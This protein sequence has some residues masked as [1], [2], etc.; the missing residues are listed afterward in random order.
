LAG[1]LGE[2]CRAVRYSVGH[3]DA[4]LT[5][6]EA[7]SIA[8]SLVEEW[9]SH[10]GPPFPSR[11]CAVSALAFFEQHISHHDGC[12]HSAPVAQAEL[13]SKRDWSMA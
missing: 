11:H 9:L 7:R 2:A 13:A 12:R 3:R 10:V 4:A 5:L 6:A 8:V 1:G